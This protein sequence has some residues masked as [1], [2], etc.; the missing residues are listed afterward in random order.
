MDTLV[1]EAKLKEPKLKKHFY[2][3]NDLAQVE[4]IIGYNFNCKTFL[5]TALIHKSYID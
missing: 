1:S 2:L 3:E 4:K 5:V